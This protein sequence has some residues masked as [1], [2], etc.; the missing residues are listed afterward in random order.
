V[1]VVTPGRTPESI[2]A[3]RTQRH[4]VSAVQPILPDTD[5]NGAHREGWLPSLS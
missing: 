5:A 3:S 1:S 4:S 2:S